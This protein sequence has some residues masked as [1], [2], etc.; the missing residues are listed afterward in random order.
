MLITSLSEARAAYDIS[1]W[2]NDP[3]GV[4]EYVPVGRNM[5]YYDDILYIVSPDR[6]ELYRSVTGRPLD[7]VIGINSEG[8]K[9][10]SLNGNPVEASRMSYRVDNDEIVSINAVTLTQQLSSRLPQDNPSGF[11]LASRSTTY[12][13]TPNY[14]DTIYGEPTFSNKILFPTS[15]VG[16]FAVVDL[17]GDTGMVDVNGLKSIESILSVGNEGRNLPFSSALDY[18]FRGVTQTDVTTGIYDNYAY[19]FVNT[20]YGQRAIVFDTLHKVFVSIDDYSSVMGQVKFF[21][22]GIVSNKT[23]RACV[24]TADCKIYELDPDTDEVL[25]WTFFSKEWAMNTQLSELKPNM[26][27][28]ILQDVKED[29]I[30]L[31]TPFVDR[32][33]QDELPDTVSK[34]VSQSPVTPPFDSIIEDGVEDV[35]YGII[36]CP[37]GGK[38]GFRL[39]G[40]ID[41]SIFLASMSVTAIVNNLSLSQE[42]KPYG[43]S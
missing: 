25:P 22:S 40:S 30:I 28:I 2:S 1:S 31:A 42:N 9:L 8:N 13:L 27:N 24:A 33:L 38:V 5:L 23:R 12:L 41:C 26:I 35:S 34:F 11:L 10:E 3:D 7:F 21:A 37:A 43:N 6:K 20:R 29:G 36:R 32:V 19:F 15:P 14:F 39:R 4:R 16:Q 18:Y 17:L